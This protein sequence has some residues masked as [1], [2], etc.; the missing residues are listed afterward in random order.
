[1]RSNSALKLWSSKSPQGLTS[2]EIPGPPG[3]DGPTYLGPGGA[4]Q[5]I[6]IRQSL[7]LY[8]PG[9]CKTMEL[10]PLRAC[11]EAPLCNASR[12]HSLR[13]AKAPLTFARHS[14]GSSQRRGRTIPPCPQDE[15]CSAKPGTAPDKPAPSAPLSLGV[16]LW[17]CCSRN[18]LHALHQNEVQHSFLTC[19]YA[20]A[21]IDTIADDPQWSP[22]G[23]SRTR[24]SASQSAFIHLH[25]LVAL[26]LAGCFL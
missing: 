20:A 3:E 12:K 17:V 26:R 1:M 25:P 19:A 7:S 21:Q 16:S 10:P 18:S 24:L 11:R 22:W 15:T 23:A 9:P 6:S 2:K 8:K 13:P 5:T 4:S 14:T